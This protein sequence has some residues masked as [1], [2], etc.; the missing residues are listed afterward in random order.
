MYIIFV[1]I[2]FL[3]DLVVRQVEAHKR[4]AQYP[5][6]KWLMMPGKDGA[7]EVVEA[8]VA[9]LAQIPL[10]LGLGVVTA[11]FAHLRT[12]THWTV[13]AIWPS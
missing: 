4:E 10:T 11:L 5:H 1:E 6:T 3:G 2:E 13:N 12:V 8:S 7:G 9:G